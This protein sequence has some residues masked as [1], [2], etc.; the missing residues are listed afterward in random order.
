LECA[1]LCNRFIELNTRPFEESGRKGGKMKARSRIL[2]ISRRQALKRTATGALALAAPSVIR[3]L[4]RPAKAAE[5]V[6]RIMG[7]TTV[8]LPDWSEF[9]K[10]TG[11][12]VEFT[13]IDDAIGVFLHE[14]EANDAGERYDL[15][16]A[17]SGPWKGLAA[18]GY[19][20]KVD[21]SK[22]SNWASVSQSV[23]TSPLI[24]G[25][26]GALW[27]VPLVMNADSFA[28]FPDRTGAPK[29]PE[30]I[31]WNLLFDNEKTKG[32]VAL[33]DS[34]FTLQHCAAYL[35]FH[36]LAEIGNPG[37]LS[38]SE[39][40]TVSNYLIERK[41]AGQFR[42]FW[43]T[44]DE[45]VSLLVN[46]E[47]AAE[48][49]WEPA[50]KEARAQGV[51]VEYAWTV[52]GYDKWMINAFIPKQAEARGN[53]EQ[54]YKALNWFLGGN[55]AAQIAILR[56]Y[57]TPRSDL[58]KSYAESAGWK[59]EQVAQIGENIEKLNKKFAHEFFWN[60]GWPDDI[61]AYE[62]EM[63]RFKNA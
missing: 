44:Y 12:K 45:Q 2:S 53:L 43:V 47:V 16:A 36:K 14:V 48:T 50:A 28:Y 20:L 27:S 41:K 61:E 6:I 52:E 35:K 55:Y 15:F 24:M 29:A 3:G 17:F 40:Q 51:N 8:A 39:C 7:V 13:P 21:D 31:S 22:I 33:D 37:N 4:I 26:E 56:G 38:S 19:L 57:V 49:A 63:S 18:K 42:S 46:Q 54:I 9:E 25:G 10:D 59:P 34:F 58:G 32:M 11:L 5:N 30:P 62:R 60:S 23:R 1:A